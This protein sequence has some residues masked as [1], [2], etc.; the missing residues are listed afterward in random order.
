MKNQKPN[1]KFQIKKECV[2]N[3]KMIKGKEQMTKG[4]EQY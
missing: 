1:S 3:G 2:K 4:K